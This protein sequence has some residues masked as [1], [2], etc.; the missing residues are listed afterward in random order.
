[1]PLRSE[2]LQ[3]ICIQAKEIATGVSDFLDV[4]STVRGYR[5]VT[6]ARERLKLLAHYERPGWKKFMYRIAAKLRQEWS[7]PSDSLRQEII[8]Q[9]FIDRNVNKWEGVDKEWQPLILEFLGAEAKTSLEEVEINLHKQWEEG[10]PVVE[11]LIGG[12]SSQAFGGIID[13]LAGEMGAA[14]IRHNQSQTEKIARLMD[15]YPYLVAAGAFD[16]GWKICQ[17]EGIPIEQGV[18]LGIRFGFIKRNT[19]DFASEQNE[20]RRGEIFSWFKDTVRIDQALGILG[21]D[22]QVAWACA[23]AKKLA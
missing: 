16:S 10:Q 20:N 8:V 9:G 19:F 23:G 22:L 14:G 11:G 15:P 18:R 17:E 2:L 7:M 4:D 21:E 5:K 1:V 3:K 13:G 6:N 12:Y